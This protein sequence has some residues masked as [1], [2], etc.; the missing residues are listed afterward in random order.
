MVY[1]CFANAYPDSIIPSPCQSMAFDT[2]ENSSTAAATGSG[3]AAV[4]RP[5]PTCLQAV[6][7]DGVPLCLHCGGPVTAHSTRGRDWD[8][9]FCSYDC[10]VEHQV[11]TIVARYISFVKSTSGS[12]RL[13]YTYDTSTSISHV[14]TGTTQAQAQTRVPFSCTC[15]CVVPVHTWLMLALVLMIVLASYV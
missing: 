11:F 8:E 10:K 15:A 9:R 6:N 13:V 12:Y 1:C 14:W 3:P 7:K 4:L 5:Q 2:E